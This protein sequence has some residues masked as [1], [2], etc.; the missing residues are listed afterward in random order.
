MKFLPAHGPPVQ[1]SPC[2]P[3]AQLLLGLQLLLPPISPSQ[4]RLLGCVLFWTKHAVLLSELGLGKRW[5]GVILSVCLIRIPHPTLIPGGREREMEPDPGNSGNAGSSV[6]MVS[7]N[8]HGLPREAAESPPV[9]MLKTQLDRDLGSLLEVTLLEQGLHGV[10]TSSA[11][12]GNPGFIRSMVSK[13]E[14]HLLG[15]LSPPRRVFLRAVL[16]AGGSAWF[17]I[18]LFNSAGTPFARNPPGQTSD[19][20]A[21]TLPMTSGHCIGC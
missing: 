15:R 5:F 8:W 7:K 17:F 9:E 14:H 18:G 10:V 6:L 11:C 19:S 13:A 3:R 20:T 4:A 1:S 12:Q 2:S 16:V 21:G